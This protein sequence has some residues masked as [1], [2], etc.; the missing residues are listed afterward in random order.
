MKGLKWFARAMVSGRTSADLHRASRKARKAAFAASAG[1]D[2]SARKL[3]AEAADS[4]AAAAQRLAAKGK[5]GASDVA[6]DAA[7]VIRAAASSPS[8]ATA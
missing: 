6:R 2:A 5:G 8:T 1:D 3:A 7:E 4:F